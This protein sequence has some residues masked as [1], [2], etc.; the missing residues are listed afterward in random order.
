M[1]SDSIRQVLGIFGGLLAVPYMASYVVNAVLAKRQGK[2]PVL[3]FFLSYPL[4]PLVSIYLYRSLKRA[5]VRDAQNEQAI[6]SEARATKLEVE[7]IVFYTAYGNSRY[8]RP[9]RNND[10]WSRTSDDYHKLL[11]LLQSV[12]EG[13]KDSK[14]APNFPL[15]GTEVVFLKTMGMLTDRTGGYLDIGHVFVTNK[16][17]VFDGEEK[18]LE[19]AFSKM[20]GYECIDLQEMIVIK[21]TDQ[22]SPKVISFGHHADDWFKFQFF[23]NAAFESAKGSISELVTSVAVKSQEYDLQKPDSEV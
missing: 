11:K 5:E 21:S 2:N 22:P 12:S 17:I 7:Q 1:S 9:P 8:N 3:W 20:F 4:G 23:L 6:E 18:L 10:E 15:K 13:R 14:E 16:R 19:W